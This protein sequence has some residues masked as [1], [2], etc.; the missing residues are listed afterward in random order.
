MK[1]E[2]E[3][4]AFFFFFFFLPA[5]EVEVETEKERR[6]NFRSLHFF[7]AHRFPSLLPLIGGASKPL[8]RFSLF[9]SGPQSTENLRAS[10]RVHSYR[11]F[12]CSQISFVARPSRSIRSHQEKKMSSRRPFRVLA[13]A[14]KPSSQA[15]DALTVNG[16][17]VP[18]PPGFSVVSSYLLLV[19]VEREREREEIVFLSIERRSPWLFFLSR[20]PPSLSDLDLDLQQQASSSRPASTSGGGAAAGSSSTVA[21]PRR[22]TTAEKQA[23]IQARATAQVKSVGFLCFMMWMAGS[24]IHLFSIMTTA[25]GIYQPL[26]AIANS[27]QVF[28]TEEKDDDPGLDLLTPR[29]L[30]CAVQV[31]GLAFALHKLNGMGLLPTTPSDYAG[32]LEAPR[33]RE[34]VGSGVTLG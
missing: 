7:Q 19:V 18:D 29:L 15:S 20:P 23:A 12:S 27:G 21:P 32:L 11:T 5:V 13:P 33:A 17:R 28:P 16:E 30:F 25:S 26:A 10:A 2:G 6:R 22:A 1:K 24:Q 8:P 31:A 3:G 4:A 9:S 34:W 14:G